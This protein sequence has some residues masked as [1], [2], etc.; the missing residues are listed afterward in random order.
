MAVQRAVLVL[1]V[2]TGVTLVT[3]GPAGGAGAA[4]AGSSGPTTSSPVQGALHSVAASSAQNAWA[5]GSQDGNALIL[6]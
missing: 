4:R 3:S 6:H 2:A 5:V 1:A